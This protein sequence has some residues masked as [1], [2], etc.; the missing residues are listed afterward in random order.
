[1]QLFALIKKKLESGTKYLLKNLVNNNSINSY[2]SARFLK[3][4]LI[5]CN[6]Q[7]NKIDKTRLFKKDIFCLGIRIFDVTN[8]NSKVN[9][10]CIMKEVEV[11]KKTNKCFLNAPISDGTLFIEIG[12]RNLQ[13]NWENISSYFLELGARKNNKLYPDDSWFYFS[14]SDPKLSVHERMYRLSKGRPIGGS[15]KVHSSSQ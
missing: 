7:F 2:I 4:G 10:T 15:E 11:S 13:D 5:E 8:S 14:S 1:M 6:W 9:S 12:F 3:N